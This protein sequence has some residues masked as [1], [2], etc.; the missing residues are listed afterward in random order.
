MSDISE[1]KP[2]KTIG[3]LSKALSSEVRQKGLAKLQ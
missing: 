2:S 1:E 3:D